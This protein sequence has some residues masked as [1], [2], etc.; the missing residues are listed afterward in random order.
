MDK[1]TPFMWFNDNAEAAVNLYMSL[2]PDSRIL[3]VTRYGQGAPF[4]EGTAMTVTFQLAGRELIALNGGPYYQLNE[5]FSLSVSCDSQEEVDR[6]WE[7][8]GEGGSYQQC[9]WLK[10]RF[11]LSWQIVPRVLIELLRDPDRA[12]AQRVTEAM[13]KM[14]KLDIGELKRAAACN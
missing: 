3:E 1:V 14:V 5:A 12:K 11:G 8:L 2:F 10:D 9:G 13:L 7:K 6:L 4:P